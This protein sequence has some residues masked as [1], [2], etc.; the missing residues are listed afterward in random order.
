[1]SQYLCLPCGYVYDEEK[2]EKGADPKVKFEDL[3]INWGCPDCGSRKYDFDKIE[4]E[5]NE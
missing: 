2:Q 4:E 5:E 1:M 3:P